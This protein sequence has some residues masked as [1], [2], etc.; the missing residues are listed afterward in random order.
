LELYD[1]GLAQRPEVVA[2]NKIDLP[3]A[4]GDIDELIAALPGR[5][6]LAVSGA[7]QEG[8]RELLLTLQRM[9]R[10]ID[11]ER[12]EEAAARPATLL[13]IRPEPRDRLE[14]TL[15]DDVFVVRSRTA[16][17]HAL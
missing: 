8:T 15:E 11:A 3:D 13:V 1:A 16:E 7:T 4:R 17:E 14:V 5:K 2:L 12:R 10:Q 9:I 6:V